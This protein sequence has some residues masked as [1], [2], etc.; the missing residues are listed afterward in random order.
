MTEPLPSIVRNLE[1]TLD[2]MLEVSDVLRQDIENLV[3]AY[4]N[5]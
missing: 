4:R 2:E 3:A 1:K 5:D